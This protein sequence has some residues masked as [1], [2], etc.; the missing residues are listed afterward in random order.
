MKHNIKITMLLILFFITAQLIGLFVTSRYINYKVTKQTGKLTW[1]ELP[2]NVERPDVPE[3]SSFLLLFLSIIFG[4][5]ILLFL[6][7]LH[8][9]YF[10]KIWFFIA[11]FSCL[12]IAFAAFMPK[13]VALV[14]ALT[15]SILKVFKPNFYVHNITELFVYAGIAAIFVPIMN[16]FSATMLLFIVSIYDFIAV[17]KIKH[18]IKLA[19]FQ[20]KEKLFAGLFIPYSTKDSRI[21]KDYSLIKKGEKPSKRVRNSHHPKE[22]KTSGQER[23]VFGT[24]ILGGGDM[25]LPLLFAGAVLKTH[26][27]LNAFIVVLFATFAL[28]YLLFKAEEKK[29]YPAMPFLTTGCLLGYIVVKLLL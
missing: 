28:T 23:Q 8:S 16:V 13:W 2:Y 24:A 29:F 26:G 19:K 20:S 22:S 1:K 6:M 7:K 14:L 3:S 12:L 4:T 21:I 27:F 9:T 18:M 11:V 25:A 10:W 5:V 15:L 17:N